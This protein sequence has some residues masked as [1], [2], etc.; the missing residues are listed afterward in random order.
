MESFKKQFF[1]VMFCLFVGSVVGTLCAM[2]PAGEEEKHDVGQ[3]QQVVGSGLACFDP[4][5]PADG[6]SGYPCEDSG[7]SR[8]GSHYARQHSSENRR[9]ALL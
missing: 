3:V 2:E 8:S 9:G 1:A 7:C 6:E 4:G 5:V